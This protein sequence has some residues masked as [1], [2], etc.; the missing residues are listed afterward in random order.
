VVLVLFV[1]VVVAVAGNMEVVGV[2]GVVE[3]LADV[4]DEM[5]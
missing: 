4:A 3:V 2:A 5:V 1:E